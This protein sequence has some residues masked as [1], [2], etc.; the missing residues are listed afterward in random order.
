MMRMATRVRCAAMILHFTQFC[1]LTVLSSLLP[2]QLLDAAR[3]PTSG[4]GYDGAGS[5]ESA[6]AYGQILHL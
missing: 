3:S 1:L 5:A 2:H 6:S 4:Q